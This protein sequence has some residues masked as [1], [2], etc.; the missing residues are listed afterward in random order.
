MDTVDVG[1]KNISC[2][3]GDV[4]FILEMK[5]Q[6]KII[7]PLSSTNTIIWDCW[8]ILQEYPQALEVLVDSI[9]NNNVW[10]DYEEISREC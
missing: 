8:I 1:E 6:L 7:S 10:S 9:E 3:V 5:G 2:R 4:N